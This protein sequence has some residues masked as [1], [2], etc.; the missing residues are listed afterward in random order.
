[1]GASSFADEIVKSSPIGHGLTK[2]AT[3]DKEVLENRFEILEL[4][5]LNSLASKALKE[6][7]QKDFYHLQKNLSNELEF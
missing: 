6:Q 3:R 4:D 7:I 2:M 1:M 5:K